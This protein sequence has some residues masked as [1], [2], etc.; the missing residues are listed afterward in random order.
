M[1]VTYIDNK[2]R[3]RDYLK[4]IVDYHEL[5]YFL[6]VRDL[7]IKYKQTYLGILWVLIKP[8][9]MVFVFTVVFQKIGNFQSGSEIPYPLL[10]MAG[11]MPWTYFSTAVSQAS[12]SIVANSGM[13]TKIYFPRLIIPVAGLLSSGV[14]FLITI[15]LYLAMIAWYDI[16]LSWKILML[17]FA[18]M[19]L[20]FFAMGVALVC[21]ATNVKFRDFRHILPFLLQ[22]GLYIS[23]IG[24]SINAVDGK[25]AAYI[26]NPIVGLIELFRWSLLPSYD[27][28]NPTSLVI[29][30]SFTIFICTFGVFYFIKSEASF[31]DRI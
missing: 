24:Y 17:P 1:N 27:L 14:D 23:P 18:V 25:Y 21:S 10:V 11:L 30:I 13:V 19:L 26:M 9:A 7:Q 12:E 8:I 4:R 6:T 3:I 22:I 31:A 16:G 29:T 28:S 5:F 15:C 2:L 20:Y